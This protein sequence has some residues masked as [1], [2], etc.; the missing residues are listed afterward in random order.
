MLLICCG[1]GESLI[2]K[3]IR[4]KPVVKSQWPV[5]M[6]SPWLVVLTDVWSEFAWHPASYSWLVD[7]NKL[8]VSPR[9]IWAWYPCAGNCGKFSSQ[10]TLLDLSCCLFGRPTIIGVVIP[11]M[12]LWGSDGRI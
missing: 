2:V 10:A 6:V 9:R 12:I 11:A 8:C 7:I 5:R 4:H 1:G 3:G